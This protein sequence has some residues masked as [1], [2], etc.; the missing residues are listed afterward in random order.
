MG[1]MSNNVNE[2]IVVQTCAKIASELV[3][4]TRPVNIEAALKDY[5]EAFEKVTE[6][7]NNR[8]GQPQLFRNSSPMHAPSRDEMLVTMEQVRQNAMP[9]RQGEFRVRIKGKQYGE[10]PD[11]IHRAAQKA[12]IEEVWDNRKAREENKKRPHFVGTDDNKTPF[13]APKGSELTTADIS[14]GD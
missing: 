1:K 10:L 9:V 3:A 14:F 4:S 5:E 12:G 2:A 13:W 11:W 8:I 6:L 7:V